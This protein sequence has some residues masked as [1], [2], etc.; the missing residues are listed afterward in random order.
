MGD[1]TAGQRP[2][3]AKSRGFGLFRAL[4]EMTE[5]N[6]DDREYPLTFAGGVTYCWSLLRPRQQWRPSCRATPPT[7]A[8]TPLAIAL[9]PPQP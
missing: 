4:F 2:G 3:S 9:R 1:E 6:R 8:A 7:A 5:E